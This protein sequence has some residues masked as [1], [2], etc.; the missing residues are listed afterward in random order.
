MDKVATRIDVE[1]MA[2]LLCCC[3]YR[4]GTTQ[5]NLRRLAS[6][7]A[8]QAADQEFTSDSLGE[9]AGPPRGAGLGG[10]TGAVFR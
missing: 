8:D 9:T 5:K 7:K 3:A 2:V 6:T 4:I 1:I 10:Q